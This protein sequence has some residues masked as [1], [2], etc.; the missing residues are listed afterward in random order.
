MCVC[1]YVCVF[2]CARQDAQEDALTK[3]VAKRRIWL[4]S[5]ITDSVHTE[6]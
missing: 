1:V 3:N 4:H 5:D 2:V 6:I